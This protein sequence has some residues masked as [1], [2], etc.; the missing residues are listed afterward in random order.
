MGCGWWVVGCGW[1][2]SPCSRLRLGGLT[3]ERTSFEK[4]RIYRLAEQLG[5]RIWDVT[6]RWDRYARD[7]VGRQIVRAADSIGA[8]LAEGIGRGTPGDNHR[9][10]RIARGSLNETKHWHRRAYKRRLLTEAT[11][12]DLKP[13]IEELAPKLNAYLRS[14]NER[15]RRPRGDERPPTTHNQQPTT[16]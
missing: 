16:H 5:D 3:M 12:K 4:L 8:N 13:L 14:I 7:T 6:L 2:I 10:V 11:V 9:F 1:N 15:A